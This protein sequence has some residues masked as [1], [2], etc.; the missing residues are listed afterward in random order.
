MFYYAAA[1]AIFALT[2]MITL[3][4]DMFPGRG[5]LLFQPLTFTH[6][7]RNFSQTTGLHLPKKST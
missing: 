5:W 6:T 4:L 3:A 7:Q 2:E 1:G